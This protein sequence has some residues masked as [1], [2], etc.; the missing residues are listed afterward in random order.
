MLV[1]SC[2]I[3]A[4][5][6]VVRALLLAWLASGLVVG[7]QARPL[8]LS[9]AF[10]A[11]L[12]FDGAYRA[13]A[14]ERDSS[15][16]NLPLAH[17]GLLPSLSLSA[18]STD[19]HGSRQF[20]NAVSQ[21]VRIPVEYNS[22]QASLSLRMPIFN[23]EALSRYRQT[24]AQVEGAEELF[25]SRALELADRL[26]TTYLQ[27]LLS[28]E[29]VQLAKSELS[30]FDAQRNRAQQRI[31]RGEGTLTEVA[32]AESSVD[33]ARVRL[34]DA[35]DSLENARRA[36]RRI[37]G[38]DSVELNTLPSDYLPAPLQ[39]QALSEWLDLA[40][41]R[42]PVLRLREQNVEA[43]RLGIE[44][45]RAGHLPRVDFVAG[46]SRNRNESI[47]SLNQTSV[48]KSMGIQ[49]NVPLYSGGAVQASIKQALAEQAKAEE[50][51]R[52]ERE[53][54]EVEIQ[55]Q[56]QAVIHGTDKIAANRRVVASSETALLGAT[57]AL[58]AGLGT[59]ADVLDAQARLSLAQRDLVQARYELLANRLRLMTIAGMPVND[60]VSDLDRLLTVNSI[61][62]RS[63]P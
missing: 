54:I 8:T 12:K 61:L 56:H 24:A 40:R 1:V 35:Y 44:R 50:E 51:L 60:T 2:R 34:L 22:P 55:R 48:L 43:A 6:R 42:S 36:L 52:I 16:M 3:G 41:M 14:Y 7:A 21:D 5:G 39:P 46:V 63:H 25:R 9:D 49:L 37:T 15:R 62:N 20:E 10:D 47:T 4:R 11:A 59:T 31:R 28:H 18:S 27:V 17:A 30:S 53:G 32:R 19:V 58:E 38:I 57:R 29:A 33:V 23:Y 45:S 13:A 26:G